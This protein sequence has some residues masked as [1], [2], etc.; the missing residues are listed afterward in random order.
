MGK[1]IVLAASLLACAAA[2][3]ADRVSKNL[4]PLA[5]ETD[6][7]WC[8]RGPSRV[9][10]ETV[11][12]WDADVRR[13]GN[14]QI[15]EKIGELQTFATCRGYYFDR[16]DSAKIGQLTGSTRTVALLLFGLFK[17]DD[18]R[19]L[20]FYGIPDRSLLPACWPSAG[21]PP[22]KPDATKSEWLAWAACNE[23]YSASL[24][25]NYPALPQVTR[26]T[27]FLDKLDAFEFDAPASQPARKA[28]EA[29]AETAMDTDFTTGQPIRMEAVEKA[30]ATQ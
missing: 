3:A 17:T 23:Q 20:D 5:T 22:V 28:L 8:G 11:C 25:D 26:V 19:M 4:K 21:T 30:M 7:P 15:T 14:C 6:A 10:E 9:V 18:L 1:W 29:L 27:R 13:A 24:V 16:L 2:E 12:R